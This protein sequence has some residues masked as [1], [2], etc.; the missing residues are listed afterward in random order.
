MERGHPLVFKPPF[1]PDP[2]T[3][4]PHQGWRVPSIFLNPLQ[5]AG[6][7]VSV[8]LGGAGG[9]G[10]KC[11][12]DAEWHRS[13]EGRITTFGESAHGVLVE[14]VGGGGDI[15]LDYDGNVS[16]NGD[17]GEISIS[18]TGD[19]HVAGDGSVGILVQSLGGGGGIVDRLLADSAGGAGASGPVSMMID[20]HVLAHGNEGIV[21]HEG[22]L[23]VPGPGDAEN[24]LVN[25]GVMRPEPQGGRRIL[26]PDQGRGQ[27]PGAR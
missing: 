12:G 1:F 8:G 9:G 27:F 3:P 15:N 18:Q 24:M 2:A 20:G 25:R 7:A 26:Q 10:G 14:S 6:G 5:M 16:T 23:L 22:A 19:I 11:F 17:G 13:N 21:N 4:R